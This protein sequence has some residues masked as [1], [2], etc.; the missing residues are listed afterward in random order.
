MIP[1]LLF[2]I[3]LGVGLATYEFS[4]RAHAWVELAHRAREI[5]LTNATVWKMEDFEQRQREAM[6]AFR[7]R[8]Q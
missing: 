2:A 1:L 5:E 4:P 6:E 7:H 3:A 8:Q